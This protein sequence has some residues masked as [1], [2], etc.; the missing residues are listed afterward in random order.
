VTLLRGV[1]GINDRQLPRLPADSQEKSQC[2]GPAEYRF[3]VGPAAGEGAGE[4]FCRAELFH[5]GVRTVCMPADD[6]KWRTGRPWVQDS[7]IAAQFTRPTGNE[8]K[9]SLPRA[10]RML[11][12]AGDAVLSALKAA[13]DRDGFILRLFN[14][15]EK[16]AESTVR[17]PAGYRCLQVNLLEER[18]GV[19]Y[20]EELVTVRLVPKQILTLKMIKRE[21]AHAET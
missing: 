5:Q 18:Q 21:G 1:E 16:T 11:E 6:T 20:L 4:L 8:G 19:D 15:A 2:L 9:P 3:E 10:G 13:E 12:L 7:R 17:I 14:P